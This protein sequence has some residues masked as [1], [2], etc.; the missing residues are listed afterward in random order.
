MVP[1]PSAPQR[2][3]TSSSQARSRSPP[4]ELPPVATAT[5]D[6]LQAAARVQDRRAAIEAQV[7]QLSSVAQAVLAHGI[8]AG[9]RV[10]YAPSSFADP[11]SRPDDTQRSPLHGREV[12]LSWPDVVI[13]GSADRDDAVPQARRLVQVR[14]QL[15]RAL[16]ATGA[17][18]LYVATDDGLLVTLPGSDWE[19]TDVT[20]S[21]LHWARTAADRPTWSVGA[22][23]HHGQG[24]RLLCAVRWPGTREVP[25]GAVALVVDAPAL[26]GDEVGQVLGPE[27]QPIAGET[28]SGPTVPLPGGWRWVAAD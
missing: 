17:T 22:T 28:A 12:S 19:A 3:S 9:G 8:P 25:G 11:A 23:D 18:W 21:E 7:L 10:L 2:A 24:G 1:V 20:P 4:P 26:L 6:V 15:A 14:H 27:G 5:D 13:E 16:A